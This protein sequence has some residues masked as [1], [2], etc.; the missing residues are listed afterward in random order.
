MKKSDSDPNL[1]QYNQPHEDE[2]E[3]PL[4]KKVSISHII[5]FS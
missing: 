4:I 3:K 1:M 5:K 2:S